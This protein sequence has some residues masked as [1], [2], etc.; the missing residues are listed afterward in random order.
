[1]FPKKIFN[2]LLDLFFPNLCVVCEK[3]LV[4]EEN[5]LCLDCLTKL[6][7]TNNWIVKNNKLE[8]TLD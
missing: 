3:K 6:P 1:M 4:E 2:A 5:F 7:K 8:Q